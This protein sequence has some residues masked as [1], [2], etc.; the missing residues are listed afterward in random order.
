MKYAVY[1][2]V[3]ANFEALEA[4][5]ED[6]E[7]A[8]V[9]KRVFLGDL[10]GYGPNP[11]ECIAL[12]RKN[13]DVILA[14]NHDWA[15]V[16]KTDASYFNPHA[17]IAVEWTAE[18]LTEESRE[19]LESLSPYTVLEEFQ[20][21]HSSPLEPD[22]WHYVTTLHD[23]LCNYQHISKICFIGHSHQPVILE[24]LDEQRVMSLNDSYRRLDENRKYL[25][26][27]GSVGQ[28]RDLNPDSCYLIFDSAAGT[29]EYR[30]V[31]YDIRKVQRKMA[32]C[33]L[34]HFL[35]ER[36]AVGR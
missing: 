4:V 10:V 13:A 29:I 8:G 27:D 35:I 12:I 11:N 9:E 31:P 33:R 18:Q 7:K 23:A 24:Y 36:L 5:L 1:S 30:R 17:R 22:A 26:N 19:F 34:P 28:P 20:A 3:H 15:A 16:G 21:A 2:D 32:E 14:G 6:M 25:I